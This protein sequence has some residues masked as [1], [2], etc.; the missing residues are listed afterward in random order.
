[1]SDYITVVCYELYIL[2]LSFIYPERHK[3]TVYLPCERSGVQRIHVSQNNELIYKNRMFCYVNRAK[4][5]TSDKAVYWP[6]VCK[7]KTSDFDVLF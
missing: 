4:K 6:F 5:M 1:V 2:A 7:W 3:D